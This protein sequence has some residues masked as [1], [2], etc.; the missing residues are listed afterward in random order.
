[1]ETQQEKTFLPV[2][3]AKM[4]REIMGYDLAVTSNTPPR[5]PVTGAKVAR[6]KLLVY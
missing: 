2:S 3:V 4:I 1:V 6:K 5:T